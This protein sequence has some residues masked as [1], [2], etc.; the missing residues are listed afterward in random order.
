MKG[1]S[2]V[3][4]GDNWTIVD[5]APAMPL[6]EMVAAILEEEGFVVAVRGAEMLADVF[7]HLG[8]VTASTT[9]VL[10]P[11]KDAERATKLIDETVTDYEGEEL[12]ELLEK[13]ERG[14]LEP[15]EW[16]PADLDPEDQGEDLDEDLEED[17][18]EELSDAGSDANGPDRPV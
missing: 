10:V 12:E 18:D 9:Y 15:G 14:E 5:V 13:M 6:A 4:N 7:S 11:E 3:M 17:L 2:L 8:S 16:D 1:E